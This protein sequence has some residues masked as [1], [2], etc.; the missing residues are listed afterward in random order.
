M[1]YVY[2]KNGDAVAQVRRFLNASKYDAGG[3]DAFIV[4]F[5][6]K[7]IDD[8]VLV[9]CKSN[10]A[11]QF[12]SGR[13]CARSFKDKRTWIDNTTSRVLSALQAGIAILRWKPDRILCGCTGELL[14]VSVLV[15]KILR[16][17]V[18]NSRHGELQTRKGFAAALTSRLNQLCIC[19]CDAIVC[20]GPFMADQIRALGFDEEKLFEFEVDLSGFADSDDTLPMPKGFS[21]FASVHNYL[22]TFI[23]RVQH[24]KGI[25]DLLNAF[26]KL[27]EIV[28]GVGLVYVGEGKDWDNLREQVDESGFTDDVFLMGK[29]EHC[30]LPNIIRKSTLILAPTRPEL[31][32]G[33]C[34][35]VLESLVLGVPVVVPN[36]GPFPYAVNDEVNGLL[37][38]P[39]SEL[40][41]LSKLKHVL[42]DHHKLENL[43]F[44]AAQTS[45]QLLQGQTSF[46]DAVSAAF[47]S[48]SLQ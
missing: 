38:E 41:L 31:G 5:L 13:I 12:K 18:V 8:E 32:E 6:R 11:S 29:I 22:I 30:F 19:A 35:V 36:F 2:I 43:R 1:K 48:V 44:G 42:M 47:K 20:H 4:D 34:M 15:A 21:K 46:G 45:C 25:F 9:I 3:P 39:G 28:L 17:P 26:S 27:R 16:V 7:R 24:S 14:W 37:F 10:Q 33:R 23:G 40:S